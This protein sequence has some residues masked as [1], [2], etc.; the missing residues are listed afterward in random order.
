M[1]KKI[2][3][4]I[5]LSIIT[6][7][8]WDN[9]V[10]AYDTATYYYKEAIKIEDITNIEIVDYDI[11]INTE[12]STISE[13]IL[14]N[15]TSSNEVITTISLPL[16][17]EDMNLFINDLS[18]NVNNL[19]ISKY[20]KT[21]N[22]EYLFKIK[23][24]SN[25]GKKIEINYKTNNDLRN[26]K[27]IKYNFAN[28]KDNTK[29]VGKLK[30]DIIFPEEDIPL[31]EEIYPWHYTFKDNTVTVEYYNFLISSLTENIIVTKE[32]YNNLLYNRETEIYNYEFI[33]NAPKYIKDG[34]KLDYSLYNGSTYEMEE[35]LRKELFNEEF[36]ENYYKSSYYNISE[37]LLDYIVLKQMIVD[38]KEN[39]ELPYPSWKYN[40][41]LTRLYVMNNYSK[42]T[43]GYE[44]NLLEN[45]TVCIDFNVTR[46]NEQIYY[47]Y[48]DEEEVLIDELN[49]YTMDPGTGGVFYPMKR[50]YC[51][52][53]IRTK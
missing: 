32:T 49:I 24:N 46:T 16:E 48:Y 4:V 15:N 23:I 2:F 20:S 41:P 7:I 39:V 1:I 37:H 47:S 42:E 43:E 30:C 5:F 11:L 33:K 26:A 52:C 34:V 21:N 51:I 44:P 28:I 3:K 6:A 53:W 38:N 13:T 45:R 8:I 36:E 10:L 17:Y 19:K 40:P 18:I 31:V 9:G 50:Q 27:T 35:K 14:L 29:K 25:E 12:N 22:G